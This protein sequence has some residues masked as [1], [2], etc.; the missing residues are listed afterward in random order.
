MIQ[1]SSRA[2]AR[3]QHL[4]AALT[5]EA[6]N[7]GMVGRLP[8]RVDLQLYQGD[9]FQMSL[10]LS[11]PDGEPAD[12]S[13]M[14]AQAQIRATHASGVAADFEANIDGSTIDLYLSHEKATDLVAQGVWDCQI[15]N[16]EGQVTTVV[17]GR[18]AVEP[19]VTR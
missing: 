8:D 14:T 6:R 13:T 1:P 10:V 11:T 5:L 2:L 4:P 18:V 3:P 9:T 15:T 12:L 19:E 7:D 17:M 16:A